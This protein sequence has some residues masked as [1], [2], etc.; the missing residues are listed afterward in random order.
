MFLKLEKNYL[1]DHFYS[2]KLVIDLNKVLT[3][4]KK[5]EKK[6]KI[7]VGKGQISDR[8]CKLNIGNGHYHDSSIFVNVE[9]S[10]LWHEMLGNISHN[11]IK[12]HTDLNLIPKA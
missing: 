11:K 3:A 9:S 1:V 2:N 8:L 6:E 10:R 5:K 4:K 7:F 12:K